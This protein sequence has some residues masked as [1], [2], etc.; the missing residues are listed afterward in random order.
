MTIGYIGLIIFLSWVF[1]V[2]KRAQKVSNLKISY[3]TIILLLSFLIA[4]VSTSTI[5]FTANTWIPFYF[6]GKV[7]TLSRN[8]KE[9]SNKQKCKS[10]V[11]R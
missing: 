11:Y 5:V 8:M 10:V 3:I 7:V 4:G 6:L 1:M 2:Y 9:S